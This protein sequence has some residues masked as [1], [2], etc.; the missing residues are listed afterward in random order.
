MGFL[1]AKILRQV[2][3]AVLVVRRPCLDALRDFSYLQKWSPNVQHV[4]D[5]RFRV[6]LVEVDCPE[7]E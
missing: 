1:I 2:F 5:S 4:A 6:A 3:I 7:L